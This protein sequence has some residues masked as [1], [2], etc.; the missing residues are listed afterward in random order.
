MEHTWLR[1]AHTQS[2]LN[3]LTLAWKIHNI[4]IASSVFTHF[5]TKP[6][7]AFIFF[8]SSIKMNMFVCI[9]S[10]DYFSPSKA[11]PGQAGY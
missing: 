8:N 3:Y 1:R 9:Q 10:E 7:D 2:F 11:F 5:D 6:A 4:I